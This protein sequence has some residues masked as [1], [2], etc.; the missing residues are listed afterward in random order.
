VGYSTKVSLPALPFGERVGIDED[1]PSLS[2][3]LGT[4]GSAVFLRPS[5]VSGANPEISIPVVGNNQTAAPQGL[6]H[7]AAR[8]GIL[9]CQNNSMGLVFV[10]ASLGKGD[11]GVSNS[12]QTP[13]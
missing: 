2:N 5:I 8:L 9:D 12:I 13:L 10:L 4:C 6:Y 7:L 1:P 11:Q 3:E